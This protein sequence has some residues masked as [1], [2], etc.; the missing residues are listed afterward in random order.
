MKFLDVNWTVVLCTTILNMLAGFAFFEASI[1]KKWRKSIETEAWKLRS[2][3]RL[4]VSLT[5][6]SLSMSLIAWFTTFETDLP[7]LLM[8]ISFQFLLLVTLELYY[9][10]TFNNRGQFIFRTGF[11]AVAFTQSI[12]F[13]LTF[14]T[15]MS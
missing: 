3:F 12:F 6:F 2:K 1:T 14:R 7:R 5:L 15:I 4:Y 11:L 10:E 13:M 9:P 8:A